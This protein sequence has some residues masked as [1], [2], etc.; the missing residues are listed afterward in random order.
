MAM[1]ESYC[2]SCGV[3]TSAFG[4]PQ[5]PSHRCDACLEYYTQNNNLS[6]TGQPLQDIEDEELQLKLFR[7]FIGPVPYNRAKHRKNGSLTKFANGGVLYA[8]GKDTEST[9]S[10]L[11]ENVLRE[12]E[13]G[14]IGVF[15]IKG[16]FKHGS[17]LSYNE[18]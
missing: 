17:V 18:D 7:L 2:V 4:S 11:Q 13:R 1:A 6:N 10:T 5:P 12:V 8:L 14:R 15:E 3:I 9:I 16:P